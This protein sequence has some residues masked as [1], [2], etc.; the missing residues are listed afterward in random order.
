MHQ[1]KR[2][3]RWSGLTNDA[4]FY[5]TATFRSFWLLV[6]EKNVLHRKD[7]IIMKG[8]FG[9][10]IN[11]RFPNTHYLIFVI[12]FSSEGDCLSEQWVKSCRESIGRPITWE[13][14]QTAP[15]E[16]PFSFHT[17]PMCGWRKPFGHFSCVKE[18]SCLFR[19]NQFVCLS[20]AGAPTGSFGS[21]NI[22]GPVNGEVISY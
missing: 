14:H 17:T 6:E 3:R 16:P 11:V 22:Y 2:G 5:P 8:I 18:T 13:S 19:R 4:T 9:K 15:K 21:R 12:R 7:D 10:I 20:P 1:D